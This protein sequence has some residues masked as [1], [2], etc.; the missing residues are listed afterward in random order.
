M[1]EKKADWVCTAVTARIKELKLTSYELA[2]RT[3]GQVSEDQVRRYITGS[4]SMSSGK[5]QHVLRVLDLNITPAV[6]NKG[7]SCER[8]TE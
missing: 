5:L 7:G 8:P 2:K 1:S 3:N 6:I 4:R